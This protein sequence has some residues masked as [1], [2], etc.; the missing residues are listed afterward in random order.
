MYSVMLEE[1]RLGKDTIGC[2]RRNA[3]MPSP[4]EKLPPPSANP[5]ARP[6]ARFVAL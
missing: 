4:A 5:K 1:R 2:G 3:M 6:Y